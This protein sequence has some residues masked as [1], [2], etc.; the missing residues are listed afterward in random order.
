MEL[1]PPMWQPKLMADR[2][3]A[4]GAHVWRVRSD[5]GCDRWDE[6]L[7]GP[8]RERLE[9]VRSRDDA[10]RQ[11]AGRGALRRLLGDYLGTAPGDIVLA[12]E[13]HGKPALA[14]PAGGRDLN[15]NVSHSGDWV[16]IAFARQSPV[17]VDI[18]KWRPV[19]TAEIAG[20]IFMKE[21]LL[22]W[23][24]L[25]ESARNEVFFDAWTLKEAY[26]KALGSGLSKD[27]RSFRMRVGSPGKKPELVW[28]ADDAEAPHRWSF[29]RLDVA[30][31]YS[32]AL[33][34]RRVV[35]R[36]FTY[37]LA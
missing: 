29:S 9:R 13:P 21:E 22:E 35:E 31:G 15:F 27:P 36:V 34:S 18:E 20:Q 10:R 33:A 3:E 2:L 14:G 30:A 24:R 6:L 8:E 5:A 25:P 4:G 12:A 7:S 37:T 17:G 11:A 19:E 28:C 26:L 32:A 1:V 23:M 16:L